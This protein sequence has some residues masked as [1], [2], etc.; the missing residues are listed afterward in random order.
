MAGPDNATPHREKLDKAEAKWALAGEV[1]ANPGPRHLAEV[2]RFFRVPGSAREGE[3]TVV[4]HELNCSTAELTRETCAK[5][6]ENVNPW[7]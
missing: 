4:G 6:A 7:G 1:E 3:P 5:A 2:P